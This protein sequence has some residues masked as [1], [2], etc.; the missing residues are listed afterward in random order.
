MS[1]D[2][3]NHV[4]TAQVMDL[5]QQESIYGVVLDGHSWQSK[6]IGRFPLVDAWTDPDAKLRE[7]DGKELDKAVLSAAPKPLYYYELDLGPQLRMASVA[8]TGMA[9]FCKGH[10]DRLRW[11]AHIPLA[12]PGEA[13]RVAEEAAELGAA[14]VE[15]GTSAAGR[16]L[17]S[18]DYDVLWERLESIG[19]PVFLHPAYESTGPENDGY[20]L[21]GVIG[22]LYELTNALQRMVCGHVL[23]RH[24]G[25]TIVA[26]L[27]GGFFPYSAG[28]LRHY[29]S[30]RPE[31]AGA[32]ADPWAYVG[33]IK[34][35]THLHDP[36]ALRFLIEKAGPEN[37]MIGTDCS[38]LS[39]TPAPM[40]ELRQAVGDDPE[41][42]ELVST[43]NA[44]EIFW[45]HEDPGAGHRRERQA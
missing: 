41:A 14:G 1:I 27:G 11:M 43:T 25:L 23:D 44:A 17:D 37:V 31:L 30:W 36:V 29:T 26:A 32:P 40:D 5:V 35:D 12:F 8:N 9:A 33:Q 34:F 2:I 15:I 45:R 4:I 13:A 10:D 7:M 19:M 42:M 6:N 21:G 16:R 39:A 24:A 28:R 22:L 3:H 18:R 38:F 20:A